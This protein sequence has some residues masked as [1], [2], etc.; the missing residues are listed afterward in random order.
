[1]SL[2]EV[3]KRGSYLKPCIPLVDTEP[4]DVDK[5]SLVE[6]TLKVKPKGQKDQTYK[7]WVARFSEGSVSD[8]IKTMKDL[9]ELWYKN[10]V[11][12]P[13]DRVATVQTIL[14]DDA[15]EQF[16]AGLEIIEE[17]YEGEGNYE[18]IHA[19]VKKAINNVSLSVFPHR[20]LETQKRW[21]RRHMKKPHNMSYRTMQSKVTN[22]NSALLK[23][24]NAT[25]DDKF[26]AKELLE[27]LEFSLPKKWRAK[28]DL[29][30]Y[31]PTKY[32]KERLL[33]ECEAIERNEPESE[34]PR[35]KQKVLKKQ[36]FA[37]G[38][39][40]HNKKNNNKTINLYCSEHGKGNHASKDC[41]KLHPELLPDKFKDN[42]NK[43]TAKKD[44]N[45][46]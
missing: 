36:K 44:S 19:D 21:M 39:K 38:K 41:W 18:L 31:V 30:G 5:T 43:K 20:A 4:I 11:D 6:F 2:S 32:S 40:E 34:H 46:A 17:E 1:M 10:S 25:Q 13:G 28:F 16:N 8:W 23:F 42:S 45:Y 27:I 37:K 7:K 35:K 3:P 24:P 26:T 22:M 33:Q 12:N 15:L 9:E 14:R 29:D